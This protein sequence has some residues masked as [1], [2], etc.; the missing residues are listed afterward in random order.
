VQQSWN[1]ST[2][3]SGRGGDDPTG[4]R[5]RRHDPLAAPPRRVLPPRAADEPIGDRVL[6][7]AGADDVL[8]DELLDGDSPARSIAIVNA[9]SIYRRALSIFDEEGWRALRAVLVFLASFV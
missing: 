9:R 2:V 4:G 1:S 7:P 3:S 8:V 6:R 5:Q